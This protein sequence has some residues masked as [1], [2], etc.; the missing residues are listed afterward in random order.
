MRRKAG[1]RVRRRKTNSVPF[2]VAP[3]LNNACYRLGVIESH[4][5]YYFFF[6]YS[7]LSVKPL[8][9]SISDNYAPLKSQW[10]VREWT[11]YYDRHQWPMKWHS[12]APHER[13]SYKKAKM[14]NC[15]WGR[16]GLWQYGRGFICLFSELALKSHLKHKNLHFINSF[17]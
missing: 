15:R 5:F 3:V 12:G 8:R 1:D 11:C 7:H 14:Q 2:S 16:C 6:E 17:S 4:F 9:K 13:L 10:N